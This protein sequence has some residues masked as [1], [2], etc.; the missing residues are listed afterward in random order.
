MADIIN[1]Y[2][3]TRWLACAIHGT[4]ASIAGHCQHILFL[5][6]LALFSSCIG[7]TP[8]V[9]RYKSF[10][11]GPDN[12]LFLQ[13]TM[14]C[15]IFFRVWTVKIKIHFTFFSQRP[16]HQRYLCSCTWGSP[17]AGMGGKSRRNISRKLPLQELS[18]SQT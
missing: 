6:S 8:L 18:K 15:I 7:P 5:S 9:Y 17:C 10:M 1:I 3:W 4:V 16:S 13:Q 12:T 14:L 11:R 2:F